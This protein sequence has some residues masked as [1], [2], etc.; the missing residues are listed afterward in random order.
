MSYQ[1][2]DEEFEQEPCARIKVFAQQAPKKW[3]YIS[4]QGYS[5]S[6]RKDGTCDLFIDQLVLRTLSD[7]LDFSA[8]EPADENCNPD[9]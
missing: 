7:T 6:Q 3:E 2:D 4:A 5:Y 9:E 1:F 8:G